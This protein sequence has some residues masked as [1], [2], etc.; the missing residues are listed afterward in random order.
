M[1]CYPYPKKKSIIL[2]IACL[3]IEKVDNGA[4][5]VAKRRNKSIRK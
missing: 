5:T 1:E 4:K 2:R 3:V